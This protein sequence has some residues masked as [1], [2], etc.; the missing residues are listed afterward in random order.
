MVIVLGVQPNFWNRP[1]GEFLVFTNDVFLLDIYTGFIFPV[2][3]SK[4][5]KNSFPLVCEFMFGQH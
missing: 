1:F 2:L 3:S 5:K 4:K